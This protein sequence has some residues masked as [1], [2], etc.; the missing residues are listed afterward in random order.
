MPHELALRVQA[1][2]A[3]AEYRSG[4]GMSESTERAI[5]EMGVN[6]DGDL[7]RYLLTKDYRALADGVLK[8]LGEIHEKPETEVIREWLRNS[9]QRK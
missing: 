8:R 5:E 7:L 3:V 4:T 2:K 1:D 9:L 6:G